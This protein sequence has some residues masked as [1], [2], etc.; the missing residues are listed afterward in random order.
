MGKMN[1]SI[2]S[3]KTVVENNCCVGCGACA[4]VS[5][6]NMTINQYGEYIPNEQTLNAASELANNVCPSLTPELNENI[7]AE[8]LFSNDCKYEPSFGYYMDCFA[9][10][11]LEED[12]RNKGTSG[13]MTTWVAAELLSS[14]LID[15]VIHAKQ[16]DHNKPSDPFY[17][18]GLSFSE[19]E[20]KESSKT[21]Y[22]VMEMSEVL[23]EI[24]GIDGR[25]LLIGVPCMIKSLRR[26]QKFNP[27]LKEKIPYTISLVCGHYKSINWSLSL[28]WGAGIAPDT[29][30]TI[31]YRTKDDG[32]PARA[33]VFR[34]E[35]KTGEI[36]Q[37]N[38]AEVA[39]GKFNAGALMLPA[40]EFC[41]DVIGETSDL[42]IG[43]AWLP[44]YEADDRG[45]NLLVVR[46]KQ[47][48]ETLLKGQTDHRVFLDQITSEE[49]MASQSGGY[50]QRKEGLSYRLSREKD[51][52][53]WVPQKRIAPGAYPVTKARKK[54]Y[55]MRS[56]L[57]TISRE[58]FVE[59]LEKKDFS[60]Y[61]NNIDALSKKLR[62]TE[63]RNNFFK[64]ALNRLQRLIR[65]LPNR[66]MKS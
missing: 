50:R 63:I 22:H 40:C 33:Y 16:V 31:Q 24:D 26:L 11:S 64:L 44:K 66:V 48:L 52:G 23:K 65:K 53:N 27:S 30:K 47:I 37:K 55:D 5:S 1:S 6:S 25:F 13:G 43:D 51:K 21:K 38:A 39:G 32:I 2:E 34:A 14:N 61:E 20:I 12:I 4:Y 42:T 54:I 28:S 62:Q 59:A 46:N 58:C 17:K 36:I 15:G 10:Y 60:I 56:E 35:P 7:L 45:T 3:I 41:D 9:G 18:Y 29:T 57:T 19:E 8:N 49:A